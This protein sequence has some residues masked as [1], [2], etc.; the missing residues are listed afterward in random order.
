[1]SDG[2]GRDLKAKAELMLGGTLRVPEGFDEPCAEPRDGRSGQVMISFGST[3]FRMK[4]SRDEGEYVLVRDGDGYSIIK[5]GKP[6]LD[7]IGF[8]KLHCHSPNQANVKLGRFA[9]DG[10]ML[11]YLRGLVDTGTVGCI[12]VGTGNVSDPGYCTRAIR[13]MHEA[14]PELP[15]GFRFGICPKEVLAGFREAGV[16]DFK[17]NL[18]TTSPRI[19][20]FLEP[21]GDL[22]ETMGFACDAVGVFGRGSVSSSLMV[23]LGEADAEFE[24]S[25]SDIVSL[26]IV[27]DIK[28]K[29]LN[30]TDR[31][32]AESILGPIPGMTAER[33][34]GFAEV[35]KDAESEH[36]LRSDSFRSLCIACRGCNL[37]PFLDYRNCR[38]GS[39][40]GKN[41]REKCRSGIPGRLS[42]W[43]A[44]GYRYGFQNALIFSGAAQDAAM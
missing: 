38:P 11:G 14:Y 8:V 29:R 5:G 4:Y 19:F 24:R 30:P 42:G 37:V 27:C 43:I 10:E 22:E 20:S 40:H 33:L 18:P 26:G 31:T 32:R 25:V 23:G 3:R 35:L 28:L 6:F 13:L 36:G 9:D 1:M 17:V 34:M 16:T 39:G 41:D 21:Q 7:G 44:G 2:C 15:I 12:S